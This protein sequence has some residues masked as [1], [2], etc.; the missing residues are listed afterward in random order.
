MMRR[1]EAIG[2]LAWELGVRLMVDA[3]HT[4]FQPCIDQ[5]VLRLQRKYNTDCDRRVDSN[6]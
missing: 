6:L 3:E 4:Y 2:Q 1:L 5:A